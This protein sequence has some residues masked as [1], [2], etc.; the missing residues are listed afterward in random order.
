M[1]ISMMLLGVV[2]GGVLALAASVLHAQERAAGRPV[3]WIWAAMLGSTMLLTALVP[4][5]QR[6][7]GGSTMLVADSLVAFRS[8]DAPRL[9]AGELESLRDRLAGSV[10]SVVV[11][12]QGRLARAVSY[13]QSLSPRIQLFAA[14]LWLGATIAGAITLLVA[15]RR[16]QH[17]SAGWNRARLLGVDVFVSEGAGPAVVGLRPMKIVLPS[18]ILARPQAEQRLVLRHEC[19]HMSA[20]DPALLVA[21]CIA[22]AFMPWNP[23]LWYGLSR[24]RLAV[25]IDCDRRLLRSGVATSQYGMLL[26]DLSAHRS[27][28]ASLPALSY[29]TSHLERRLF[30]MTS[31]PSRFPLAR[32]VSG[33]VVAAVLLLAACES[34]LPTSAEVETMDASKAVAALSS[35]PGVDTTRTVYVIDGKSVSKVDAN[36]VAAERIASIEVLK[37]GA[38]GPMVRMRTRVGNDSVMI[39]GTKLS[40]TDSVVVATGAALTTYR[41]EPLRVQGDTITLP[42]MRTPLRSRTGF[43]GVFMIDG[44]T[45][46]S[47]VAN[48]INPNNISSIEVVKGEAA[49]LLSTDPRA[50]NGIIKITTKAP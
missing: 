22:V 21:S 14:A 44:K 28:L 42:N 20:H 4:S 45:V 37:G 26:L 10:R 40:M 9:P 50:A 11:P 36:Q 47:D 30:A 1:T 49:R 24:L 16:V 33:G 17:S 46:S 41:R 34:R 43:E 38:Q 39:A 31:R 12:L 3:R 23:F 7:S 8:A 5:R 35:L 13:T 27:A 32:R 18:W 15:Y 25:E 48:R 6:I 2:I 19:E 29:S